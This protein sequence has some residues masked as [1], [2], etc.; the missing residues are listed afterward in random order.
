MQKPK[1]AQMIK[2]LPE[3][4]EPWVQSLGQ[5]NTLEKGMTTH[6]SILSWRILWTEELGWLQPMWSQRVGHDWVTNTVGNKYARCV[7]YLYNLIIYI[8]DLNKARKCYNEGFKSYWFPF[9]IF[10]WSKF[11]SKSRKISY[12]FD[13]RSLDIRKQK[14]LQ[15]IESSQLMLCI[16][17]SWETQWPAT[18]HRPTL[19]V[20][21][22][23]NPFAMWANMMRVTNMMMWHHNWRHRLLLSVF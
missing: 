11:C 4:Q 16:K 23:L 14:T 5:E 13:Y 9:H 21:F 10:F 3:M 15:M 17:L 19:N 1:V 22:C 12:I 18:V 2:K 20:S 7:P 8:T 6:S